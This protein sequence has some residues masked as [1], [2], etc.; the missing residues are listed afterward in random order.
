MSS[1]ITVLSV[2]TGLLNL[3]V[4]LVAPCNVMPFVISRPEVQLA[5][6]AGTVTVSPSRAEA[7]AD[8]TSPSSA[9][10]ASTV[11]PFVRPAEDVKM[12][13]SAITDSNECVTPTGFPF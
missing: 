6:P 9:L 2:T 5:V 8:L 12:D 7:M 3:P 4:M 1:R 13:V 11:A 10:F